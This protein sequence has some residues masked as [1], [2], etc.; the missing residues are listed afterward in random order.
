[1]GGLALR[2]GGLVVALALLSQLLLPPYLEHRVADRLTRNGGSAH[3]D[4]SAFPS[5]RLLFGH[6]SALHIHARGLSVDL[7]EGGEDVFNRL[8]RFGDVTITVAASRAGPFSIRSFRLERRGDHRFGV[9]VAG[10]ATA[11]DVARYAGDQLAGGF[12]QALAGLATSAVGGFERRI[13]VKVAMLIDSSTDPPR[14]VAVEGDVAGLPAGP[15]AQI[16]TNA[17]LSSL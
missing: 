3:V 2:L 12:G 5:A 4:M 8:D 7:P 15:L 17:L 6:G 1:M 9:L 11:G 14:A 13:P 10:D 16:V